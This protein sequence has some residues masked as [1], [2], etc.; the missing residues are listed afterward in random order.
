MEIRD[1]SYQNEA[2][3]DIIGH[4]KKNPLSRVLLVAPT[5]SGKTVMAV[6]LVIDPRL[7][8]I[9]LK[10]KSRD[11]LRI[12]YKCHMS[13]LLTQAKRR[14]PEMICGEATLEEWRDPEYKNKKD[15]EICYQMYSEKLEEDDD[16]DLIIYDECQHEACLTIQEFLGHAGK[17]PSLGMTATP[18][19]PDNC[20]IKF[21]DIVEPL[22]REE[23]V[24]NGFICETDINTI[25]DTSSKDKTK[26]LKEIIFNFHHE[27]KQTMIF[28]RTKKEINIMVD[29][30]NEYIGE[31]LARGCGIGEEEDVDDLLDSFACGEFKF[32]ISCMKL[33][34]GI[35]VSGV[36]DVIIAR[37]VGSNIVL[38]QIIGRAARIDVME[39]RVWEFVN[40][41]SGSNLDTTEIV[42]VP[43]AHRIIN[44]VNGEFL[45]RDFKH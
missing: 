39:C 33:S 8:E 26:L 19:R 2:V 24:M 45:V 16:I 1:L 43:R 13:R 11:Y 20:L 10:D 23:A 4:Y 5:G 22:T 15:I 25:V 42:G 27:M 6:K 35:D 29:Y 32:L 37:N 18:D 38:N 17:F 14:F 30:I 21:D 28:V 34:E 7:K 9:L 40:A 31:G 3:T 44:K 41:L 36:T 12:V